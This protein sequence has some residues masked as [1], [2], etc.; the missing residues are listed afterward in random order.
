MRYSSQ[1]RCGS[2]L[3]LWI[4]TKALVTEVERSLNDMTR[5]E[6]TL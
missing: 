2:I 3:P 1:I 4:Y 5:K 6:N